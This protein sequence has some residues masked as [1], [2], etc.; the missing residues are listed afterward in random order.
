MP[1]HAERDI[2]MTYLSGDM[3]MNTR[4]Q[5]RSIMW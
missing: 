4:R 5:T 3:E 1:M 2:V